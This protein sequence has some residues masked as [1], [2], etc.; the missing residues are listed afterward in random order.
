MKA[1]WPLPQVSGDYQS[2]QIYLKASE[3]VRK[4]EAI[5]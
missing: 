3:A 4:E 5:Q 2:V 1:G